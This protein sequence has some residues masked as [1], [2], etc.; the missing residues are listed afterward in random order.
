MNLPQATLKP[1]KGRLRIKNVP[2]PWCDV[3]DQLDA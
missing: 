1:V 3:G 2:E